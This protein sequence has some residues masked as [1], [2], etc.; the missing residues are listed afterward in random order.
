MND[1]ELDRL[2]NS[3][4]V[5]PTRRSL[6]DGLMRQFPRAERLGFIRPLRWALVITLAWAALAVVTIAVNAAAQSSDSDSYAVAD[7]PI[8][9]F[10]NHLYGNLLEGGEVRRVEG[11]VA[12]IKQSDPKVYVDGSL[13]APLEYGPA[14]TMSVLVPQEGLYSISLY[15][16]MRLRTADGRPTGWVE[17]GHIHGNEIEFQA[18]SKQVRIECSQ[19][20]VDSD[21]PVFA[22]RRQ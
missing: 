7:S 21:G 9:R 15:R 11:I 20:I 16:Y 22:M 1:N 8:V 14:K 19:P 17:A 10:L 3:W 5:P 12:K 6:R 2:L 13:M 4:D 18:G